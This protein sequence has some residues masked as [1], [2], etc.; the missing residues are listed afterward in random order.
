MERSDIELLHSLE[1]FR[2]ES[3]LSS[4]G[5]HRPCTNLGKQGNVERILQLAV[6]EVLMGMSCLAARKGRRA[7]GCELS[8]VLGNFQNLYL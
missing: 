1:F 2:S 4:W 3:V 6:D 8:E 7:T 5:A